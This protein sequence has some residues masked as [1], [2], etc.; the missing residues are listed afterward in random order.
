MGL[1]ASLTPY[2]HPTQP[3]VSM[4]ITRPRQFGKS[5]SP[6]HLKHSFFVMQNWILNNTSL[7]DLIFYVPYTIEFD[8]DR[9]DVVPWLTSVIQHFAFG[10]ISVCDL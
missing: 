6:F 9:L 10:I 5:L 4:L 8:S 2:I 1:S 3:A 7:V